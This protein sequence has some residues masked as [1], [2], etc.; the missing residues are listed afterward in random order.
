MCCFHL[1]GR[2]LFWHWVGGIF[3]PSGDADGLLPTDAL[4]NEVILKQS[5]S[6]LLD[7]GIFARELGLIFHLA[8]SFFF[9]KTGWQSRVSC[10]MIRALIQT[11]KKTQNCFA[12]GV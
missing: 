4:D 12:D 9:I 2:V 10:V 11:L 6:G 5:R 7:L 3:N 1:Y 8:N